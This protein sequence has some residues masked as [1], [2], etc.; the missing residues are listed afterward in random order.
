MNRLIA[1][2]EDAKE[3]DATR[4]CNRWVAQEN[5]SWALHCNTA[6]H[7]NKLQFTATREL[8][9][10][11]PGRREDRAIES[12]NTVRVRAIR[13]LHTHAVVRH[14]DGVLCAVVAA[15]RRLVVPIPHSIVIERSD[16]IRHAWN[17]AERIAKY[18]KLPVHAMRDRGKETEKIRKR[19]GYQNKKYVPKCR[20]AN[21]IVHVKTHI[22]IWIFL[23]S[24]QYIYVYTHTLYIDTWIHI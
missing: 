12:A 24:K 10:G 4:D 8:H 17:A 15:P 1:T 14:I 20:S 2:H 6:T 9:K 23:C 5:T 7:C 13:A 3:A 19:E 18:V 21:T 16:A 11:A 22:C